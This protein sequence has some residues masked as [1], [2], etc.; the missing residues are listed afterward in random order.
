MK[1]RNAGRR[2]RKIN[3]KRYVKGNEEK[4]ASGDEKKMEARKS[5]TKK[6]KSRKKN[7]KRRLVYKMGSKKI[8]GKERAVMRGRRSKRKDDR[9]MMWKVEGMKRGKERQEKTAKGKMEEE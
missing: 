4:L 5:G 6:K 2:Q 7:R 1:G 3:D 9:Q 8:I